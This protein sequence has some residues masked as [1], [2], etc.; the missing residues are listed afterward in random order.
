[1]K[2]RNLSAIVVILLLFALQSCTPHPE[3]GLLKRYFSAIALNDVTTM[4]TMALEPISMD[5]EKWEIVNVSDEVIEPAKL[6]EMNKKELDL[7]KKVEESV[8]ITLDAKDEL[9]DAEY[10]RDQARTRSARRAAVKKVKELQAKYDEIYDNHQK[11]QTEY[12]EAKA[13]TAREEQITSF[14]LG[15]GDI[16][17]IRDLTGNV[18]SKE[19]E[20]KVVGKDGTKNYKLYLMMYDLK[21]EVLNVHRRGQWKIIKFELID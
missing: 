16:T 9:L 10:E 5:V 21:D 13:A 18:H 15:A 17:N 20:V 4:S 11:L 6:P 2:R 19:V 12:N 8:G 7:K 14:S 3:E 1:M